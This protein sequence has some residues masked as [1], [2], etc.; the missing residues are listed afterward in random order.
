M[1]IL[2]WYLIKIIDVVIVVIQMGGEEDGTN[3]HAKRNRNIRDA[4]WNSAM[5]VSS[6]SA[7][8]YN[9]HYSDRFIPVISRNGLSETLG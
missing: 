7:V 2:R 4:D 5:V 3:N 1:C 6:S 8:W 9:V